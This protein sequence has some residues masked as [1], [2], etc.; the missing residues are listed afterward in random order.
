MNR[1]LLL[2]SL[3]FLNLHLFSQGCGEVIYDTFDDNGDLPAEWVEYNTSGQ[4][5]VSNGRMVFDFTSSNPSAYRRVNNLSGEFSY[6]LTVESQKN[7][8]NVKLNLTASNGDLL[9]GMVFGNGGAKNIM[10]ATNVDASNNP[11]T[12]IGLLDEAFS[13][14]T[15]YTVTLVLNTNSKT[16]DFYI[17]GVL[18]AADVDFLQSA[19]DF[20]VMDIQQIS[21]YGGSGIFYVDEII[22]AQENVLRQGLKI[23]VENAQSHIS[24]VAIGSGT[25]EY[26][27]AVVDGFQ[28]DV[29]NAVLT[30]NDCNAS[31]EDIDQA[32]STLASQ[33]TIFDDSR[34]WVS[35]DIG[36]RI[37]PEN[38]ICTKNPIWF[39]GNNTYNASGQGLWDAENKRC[40]YHV[41]DLANYT[42]AAGYR[43]P[44]GTMANLYRWKRA[45][46]PVDE[47]IDNLNSHGSAG[48]LSNEFGPDE[49]GQMV[50][51]THMTNGVIV[52]AFNYNTPQ[53][54][55]DY[56][57]YMNAEVGANPNGGTDWAEVRAANGHPVPYGIKYWEIGNELSGDWE[58][59]ITNYPSDGDDNRGGD[60]IQKGLVD[61]YVNG[62]YRIFTNQR[63]V[64]QTSWEQASCVVDGS[65]NQE[66]YVKFAPVDLSST[67]I[68]SI[69]NVIWSR[70]ADFSSSGPSDLH[71]KVDAETGKITFGDGVNGAIPGGGHNILLNYRSGKH[72]GFPDYY[73]AMKAVDP[74]I[75]V[76]SCWEAED[77]YREMAAINK[78]FDGV[79]KHYYPG[80]DANEGDEYKL[81]MKKAVAYKSKITSHLQYLSTHYN[82]SLSGI[83]VKQHLT[84][85][86]GGRNVDAVAQ[87]CIMWYDVINSYPNE[88]GNM[89]AHSYFKNDNTPMVNTGGKFVSAKGLPYHIFTHLHQDNFIEAIYQG[90]SYTYN[91]TTIKNS[92]P[93]ASINENG[94]VITL[95]VPNTCD[96]K[97]LN[98]SIDISNYGFAN[99]TV[100]GKK[101][102]AKAYDI[103]A[104]NSASA[105]AEVR[106]EGPFDLP[107]GQTVDDV[108]Y[109]YSVAVYQWVQ[110]NVEY[111]GDLPENLSGGEISKDKSFSLN[112]ELKINGI[113]YEKGIAVSSGSTVEYS[114]NKKYTSFITEFGL[115]DQYTGGSAA[116]KIYV[117]DALTYASDRITSNTPGPKL[118]IDVTDASSLRI[119]TIL[120][121]NGADGDYVIFG[122]ARLTVGE[123]ENSIGSGMTV[124]HDIQVYPNPIEQHFTL[125]LPQVESGEIK[126]IDMSGE[127]VYSSQFDGVNQIFRNV[128]NVPPGIYI[129]MVKTDD[130]IY[131]TK[132]IKSAK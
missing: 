20:G 67:F 8:I 14:N 96:D 13:S 106:I 36:I 126:L 22:I 6:S 100:I 65:E 4:V 49:F 130:L 104:V 5:S 50:E 57:E 11:A 116:V 109:P 111:L 34:N 84:E 120:E 69:N 70:V 27:Q 47:R 58:L 16:I 60:N 77:F 91:S 95:V 43:F 39:G 3:A 33:E 64:K 55:A 123:I 79:A 68:L 41:I 118:D 124:S 45:I 72:A 105:P 125:Q 26:M 24:G 98:T 17:D 28:S 56:V 88:V 53:D 119:E 51:N 62:G 19:S 54:A 15:S 63:A 85:F 10:Y 129:L 38:I 107:L 83:N 128:D 21:M 42:G 101:W 9:T 18:K 89:M 52:V 92:Y 2:L 103:S 1:I 29:N 115:D 66:F 25:G 117:D 73:E 90:G 7:W 94:N 40:H 108:I 113:G 75:E 61:L 59:G 86:F 81:V 78:P 46:G 99:K 127:T 12:F 114:L 112:E 87:L 35:A 82:P 71:F 102:I 31:Q 131:A 80:G 74:S 32:V 76:I 48:P 23:A 122:N 132:I 37:N 110:E 97:K 121:E 30:L 44:G 93:T